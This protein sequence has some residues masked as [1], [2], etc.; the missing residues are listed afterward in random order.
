MKTTKAIAKEMLEEYNPN[1][2]N[3]NLEAEPYNIKLV[4][5]AKTD[6]EKKLVVVKNYKFINQTIH[7]DK[8]FLLLLFNDNKDKDQTPIYFTCTLSERPLLFNFIKNAYYE[9]KYKIDYI[10]HKKRAIIDLNAILYGK[11]IH[12]NTPPNYFTVNNQKLKAQRR[13]KK[14]RFTKAYEIIVKEISLF[15]PERD[16]SFANIKS[17]FIKEI[18]HLVIPNQINQ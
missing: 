9:E 10:D 4:G 17:L 16:L 12:I 2:Q 8:Y 15:I 18:E 7:G 11:H 6:I 1:F 13:D 5:S 14:G 3:I